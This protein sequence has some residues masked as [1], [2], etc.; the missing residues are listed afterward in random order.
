MKGLETE[1]Y[2]L[3]YGTGDPDVYGAT[4]SEASKV[5][6]IV[7]QK[8]SKSK[9][10]FYDGKK[11]SHR[12][13]WRTNG[14]SYD[15]SRAMYD[16]KDRYGNYRNYMRDVKDNKEYDTA[17]S[18]YYAYVKG[19]RVGTKKPDVDFWYPLKKASE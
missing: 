3:M 10:W 4:S 18:I 14:N 5:Y 19:K 1:P 12:Y 9:P 15:H 11:W 8:D 17:V 2:I 7:Y 6:C 16:E 13:L